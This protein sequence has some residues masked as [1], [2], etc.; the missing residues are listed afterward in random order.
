MVVN[1]TVIVNGGS[2][3]ELN[4]SDSTYASGDSTVKTNGSDSVL[5]TR[6]GSRRT[7][8]SSNRLG[9][10]LSLVPNAIADSSY[11]HRCAFGRIAAFI[12][13]DASR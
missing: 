4:G 1:G 5:C 10:D 12:C 7:N 3:V 8:G 13:L 6:H 9:H 11:R 2:H